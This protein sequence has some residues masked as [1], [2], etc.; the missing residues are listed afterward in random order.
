[1]GPYVAV[2]GGTKPVML[3][4][5]WTFT[6]NYSQD[7]EIDKS[8]YEQAGKKWIADGFGKKQERD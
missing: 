8:Q 7:E 3:N 5:S 4:G 2:H 6:V 1:M